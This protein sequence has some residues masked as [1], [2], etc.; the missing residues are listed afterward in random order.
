LLIVVASVLIIIRLCRFGLSRAVLYWGVWLVGIITFASVLRW[1]ATGVRLQLP[2]FV[3]AAPA[4]GIAWPKQ[5]LHSIKSKMFL[6]I[7]LCAGL[8]ALLVNYTRP[9]V[10]IPGRPRSYLVQQP[11]ARLFATRPTFLA[12][13][14]DAL[15]I[16]SQSKASQIG[17]LFDT[18]D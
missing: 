12:P 13:Y 3:L 15:G 16:V 1:Q 17:A 7:L 18:E 11:V 6:L 10:T 5:W 14:V 4:V 9:L 8:P 2:G